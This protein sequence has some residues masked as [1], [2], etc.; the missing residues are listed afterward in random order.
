[1]SEKQFLTE[2]GAALT[3]IAPNEE[4]EEEILYNWDGERINE[5]AK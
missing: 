2:T 1:M 3:A 4:A 5:Q